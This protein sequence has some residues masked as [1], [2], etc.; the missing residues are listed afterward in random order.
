MFERKLVLWMK[1]L[2]SS[3]SPS[4][5]WRD[6]WIMWRFILCQMRCRFISQFTS[7]RLVIGLSSFDSA[8]KVGRKAHSD[9]SRTWISKELKHVVM[10]PQMSLKGIET[11]LRL[12]SLWLILYCQMKWAHPAFSH[13]CW[14]PFS[15]THILL[16]DKA[17]SDWCAKTLFIEKTLPNGL[18]FLRRNGQNHG[19][20]HKVL[21]SNAIL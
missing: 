19:W 2:L 17:M 4:L 11:V 18:I 8:L 3:Y 9:S 7:L 10:M 12:D 14:R 5:M 13:D 6:G 20:Y 16:D 1:C 21:Q 15:S